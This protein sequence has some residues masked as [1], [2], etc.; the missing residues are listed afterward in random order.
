MASRRAL[1][2][3]WAVASAA[4][5]RLRSPCAF[6][7]LGRPG[8]CD[9][10]YDAMSKSLLKPMALLCAMGCYPLA[11]AA[12]PTELQDQLVTATRTAQTVQES[13]AAGTVFDRAQIEQ[14]QGAALPELLQKVPGGAFS[15]KS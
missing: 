7:S 9:G 3:V 6:P 2:G 12:S 15:N 11:H 13:L 14:S 10:A 5:V 4:L 8:E 1:S